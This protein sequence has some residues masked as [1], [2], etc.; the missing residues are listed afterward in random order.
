ML[1][2]DD[3]LATGGTVGAAAALVGQAGGSVAAA[4]FLIELA[5]LGARAK[6]E[7]AGVKVE[8]LLSY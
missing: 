7:S 1:I 3:L 5:D 2:I 6:L 8:A 4:L